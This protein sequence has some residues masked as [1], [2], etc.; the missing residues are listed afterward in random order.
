MTVNY[1]ETPIHFDVYGEGKPLILLHGFLEDNQIWE[2][3]IPVLKEKHHVIC[4]D[5]FGHGKTPGYGQIHTMEAMAGSVVAIMQTLHIN[6]ADLIGH[7]MGGYVI[8]AFLEEFPEKADRI[9]LL[10]STSRPDRDARKNERDQASRIVRKNK[11]AFVEPA[12]KDLLAERNRD[13]FRAVIQE[14]IERASQLSADDIAAALQ[15]MKNR[16][17]RTEVLK[18]FSGKKQ[19]VTGEDDPIIPIASVRKVA[20]YANTD[21]NVLPDGHLSYIEQKEA[22]IE[23]FKDFLN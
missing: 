6:Q 2:P 12:I 17:D 8:M 18:Y 20:E 13:E 10:N 9:M 11:R 16:K 14:H 7:S 1:K 19:L 22:V 3:F 21:L 4:P 23:G 5:L 15:G